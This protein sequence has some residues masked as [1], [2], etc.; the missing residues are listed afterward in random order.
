MAYTLTA[1]LESFVGFLKLHEIN[2]T[3]LCT[4]HWYISSQDHYIQW[5]H[6]YQNY[7]TLNSLKRCAEFRITVCF[8]TTCISKTLIALTQCKKISTLSTSLYS[9]RLATAIASVR[10]EYIDD[11]RVHMSNFSLQ[12]KIDIVE[13]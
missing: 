7:F 2:I 9:G 6:F 11:F 5:R 4:F 3:A 10:Y 8:F 1:M 13:L 12:Q